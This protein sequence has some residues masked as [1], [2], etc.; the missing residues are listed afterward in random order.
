[1]AERLEE[2]VR[3]MSKKCAKNQKM[4]EMQIQLDE[5]NRA[6]TLR[7]NGKEI[8]IPSGTQFLRQGL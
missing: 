1:M 5:R 4:R 2:W 7:Y 3:K 8:G 6:R